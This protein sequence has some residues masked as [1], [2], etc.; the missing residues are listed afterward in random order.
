MTK[1]SIADNACSYNKRQPF[2]K[3]VTE[4]DAALYSAYFFAPHHIPSYQE[5]PG[6]NTIKPN[7]YTKYVSK[8][9]QVFTDEHNDPTKL[10]TI[11]PEYNLYCYNV[12]PKEEILTTTTN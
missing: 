2:T 1:L 4:P 9:E 10:I 7:F 11:K 8:V 12:K 3:T 5:R 6:N